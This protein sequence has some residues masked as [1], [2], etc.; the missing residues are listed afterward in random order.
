MVQVPVVSNV[1]LEPLTVHTDA[2]V[3]ENVTVRPDVAVALTPTGDCVTVVSGIAGKL[4]VWFAFVTVNVCC[5]EGA[6]L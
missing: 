4:I 6:G 1:T 5:T 2:V 3:D